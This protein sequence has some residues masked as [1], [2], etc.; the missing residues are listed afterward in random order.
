MLPRI[1]RSMDRMRAGVTLVDPS[2][3][4]ARSGE[5]PRLSPTDIS[6]FVRREQCDRFLRL[7]MHERARGRQFLQ[8]YG[9]SGEEFPPL[10]SR[11][12]REFEARIEREL[13]N[14][15]TVGA[16]RDM[17]H[18]G[19]RDRDDIDN[20]ALLDAVRQL[21][22]GGVR[23]LFQPRV[24]ATLAGWRVTGDIDVLRVERDTAGALRVLIADI[25]SSDQPLVEHRLQIAFYHQMIAAILADA[26]LPCAEIELGVIYRGPRA[27]DPRRGHEELDRLARDAA[28]A[29]E[30]L[31]LADAYLDLLDDPSDYLASVAELVTDAASR[32]RVIAAASFDSLT[33]ALSPVC[34]GCLFNQFCLKWSAEHDD[35]ALLPLLTRPEKAALRQ[36]GVTRVRDLAR[37]KERAPD[38]A[39]AELRPAPGLQAAVDNLV[40]S[41]VGARLD[42]LVLRAQRYRRSQGDDYPVVT[43]L[44][45]KGYGSLPYSD[46]GQSP[47]LVRVFIDAQSD[48]LHDRVYLLG[49]LVVANRD[50]T[51][52]RRAAVVRLSDGPPESDDLERALLTDW[53]AETVRA[54]VALAHPDADGAPR[55]PIHLIFFDRATR[56]TLLDALARH[57]QAVLGAT[58]LYDFVTQIAAFDSSIA[59]Y[60]DAEIHDRRNYPIL[61]QSLHAVASILRFNW[62]EPAPF[63]EL[64]H[65]RV[66]DSRGKLKI[67]GADT[68]ITRR[69]HFASAIPL[70][71]AYAAWGALA[72]PDPGDGKASEVGTFDGVDLATLRAFS[73]RRLD[74]LEWIADRLDANR[75]TVKSTFDLP[76]LGAFTQKAGT[77]AQA[78]DEFVVIERQV[79]LTD[80]KNRRRP[81]PEQRVLAGDTLLVRYVAADQPPEVAEMNR[82]NAR[83]AP[84]LSELRAAFKAANPGKPVSLSRE[85][86]AQA[87][88]SHEGLMFRLRVEPAAGCGLQHTLDLTSIK[89]GD[90]LVLCPRTILSRLPSEDAP[91]ERTPTVKQMLGGARC[92]LDEVEVERDARG[93]AVRTWAHVRVTPVR[94]NQARAGFVFN[95]TDWMNQ[96][97]VDGMLYTL[98]ADP[99]DVAGSTIAA[100]T[101]NLAADPERMQNTLYERLANRANWRSHWPAAAAEA[102]LRFLAG[103]EHAS[104]GGGPLRFEASKRAYIAEHG[105][106]PMLLVQGPPG[107]GKSF[108]T[109]YALLA[110]MQGAMA[111]SEP[112][113]VFVSCHT[114]AATDVLLE[115]IADA[116]EQLRALRESDPTAFERWFDARLLNA[117]LWRI[118]GKQASPNG[119]EA[120]IG[121]KGSRPKGGARPW[122]VIAGTNWCVVAGTP[123]SIRRIVKDR[124]P[125][126]NGRHIADCLVLDEA[127]Q[128]NLPEAIMAAVALKSDGRV[129]VVGDHRQMPPIVKHDWEKERRRTFS[130][131]RAYESLFEALRILQPPPPMIA[132]ER[133]FRLHPDMA[134]YLR[135]QIYQHDGIAFHS[136]EERVL[137]LLAHNDPF[138]STVLDP[139]YPITMVLHDEH[140][141]QHVNI[142]EQRLILPILQALATP[143]MRAELHDGVG[144]VVPHRAQRAAL[145]QSASPL[146]TVDTV[147]RFQGDEREVIVV[148][149]TESDPYYLLSAGEF[150]LDPRRLTVALSRARLKVILVASRTVFTLFSNDED[151]FANARLWKNLLRPGRAQRLWRSESDGAP[152]GVQVEVWGHKPFGLPATGTPEASN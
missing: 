42:E 15:A 95:V 64:F 11:A 9:V 80:W 77:L 144:V 37:L 122:D 53:V 73:A 93:D 121:Y 24:A 25:K 18:P 60:L 20:D 41:R 146:V 81:A 39:Y 26:G 74:A 27:A 126:I 33:F 115:K 133:S 92:E 29:A 43:T 50:G 61:C 52:D 87:G 45:N 49:A 46:A 94:G 65:A 110:R 56:T 112:F 145:Q 109:A 148:S 59:S 5:L 135:Q 79:E 84:L 124:W 151:L 67:D 32:A 7:R 107:T 76:D 118:D 88:W 1:N 96:P 129:I 4:A 142:V 66:F 147:E 123:S 40:A 119:A 86:K 117:H 63:R 105:D 83:R 70:E 116:R 51:P 102:Q 101:G 141:S 111:A 139:R 34:D 38:G 91:Q 89:Q 19:R 2:F 85:Q 78:L 44:P 62:D 98:D 14:R 132:F 106:A 23:M 150:L 104:L 68:W 28:L 137:P 22:P 149:A 35:L 58:P 140:D 3:A 131:F 120:L 100:L 125:D 69:A 136:L 114:H 8:L 54:I 152:F 97:L 72:A 17:R 99:N 30:R 127:S 12:G 103:L 21:A 143:D 108:T 128:M 16:T 31:G 134:E 13:T 47:N 10:L 113:R 82:E 57:F 138:L 90:R 48:Y 71:Y 55:A 36:A 130:E 75:Y 6:E